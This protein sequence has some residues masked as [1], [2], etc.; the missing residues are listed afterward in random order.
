MQVSINDQRISFC[1]ATV[2]KNSPE[3]VA[4]T[5]QMIP[6]N[7]EFPKQS[8]PS[9]EASDPAIFRE[10]ASDLISMIAYKTE[11]IPITFKTKS[12]MA[13]GA[14]EAISI[15]RAA[16]AN[17]NTIPEKLTTQINPTSASPTPNTIATCRS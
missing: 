11:L 8:S 12:L 4:I 16:K 6:Q 13:F 9:L 17:V 1:A 14:K 5:I 7:V 10:T 2:K 15:N 3:K